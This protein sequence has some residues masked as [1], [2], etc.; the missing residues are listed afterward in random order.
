VAAL[1]PVGSLTAGTSVNVAQ[2]STEKRTDA[3]E[4]RWAGVRAAKFTTP[5]SGSTATDSRLQ[6]QGEGSSGRETNE[7]HAFQAIAGH[8]WQKGVK[9]RATAGLARPK[10]SH[11]TQR[12]KVSVITL[13]LSCAWSKVK[14]TCS[15]HVPRTMLAQVVTTSL[16]TGRQWHGYVRASVP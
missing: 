15:R 3:V 1:Q 5:V 9:G 6:Q 2:L 4:L 12:A 8:H 16:D 13:P 7:Q 11:Q 14:R 10:R